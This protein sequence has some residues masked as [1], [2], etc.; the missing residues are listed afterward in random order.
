MKEEHR[1]VQKKSFKRVEDAQKYLTM[2]QASRIK[3]EY[4]DDEILGKDAH[5]VQSTVDRIEDFIRCI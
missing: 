1:N 5:T 3:A 4:L 2:L